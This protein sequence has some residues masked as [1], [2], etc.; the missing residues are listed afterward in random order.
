M[1]TSQVDRICFIST[2]VIE[3]NQNSRTEGK[4]K[5][6]AT[7]VY[8]RDHLLIRLF[9]FNKFYRKVNNMQNQ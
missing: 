2:T 3:L 9:K 8:I 5:A 7:T 6:L 4:T 1:R